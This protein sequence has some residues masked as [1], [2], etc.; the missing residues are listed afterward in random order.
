MLTGSL[1]QENDTGF[2]VLATSLSKVISQYLSLASSSPSPIIGIVG[3]DNIA[4]LHSAEE[5]RWYKLTL[6]QLAQ[7]NR[8]E[9]AETARNSI[10]AKQ[11]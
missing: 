8:L 7:R 3:P 9:D 1:Y 11:A 6:D 4:N 2:H 10:K 5:C